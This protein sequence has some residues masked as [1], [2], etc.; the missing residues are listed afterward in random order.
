MNLDRLAADLASAEATPNYV[1]IAPNVCDDGH[2]RTCLDGT[3]G[4]LAA[5]DRFLRRLVPMIT[6][7]PAFATDGLLIV[8]F[9]EADGSLAEDSTAVARNGRCPVSHNKR[10]AWGLVVDGLGL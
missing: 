3:P 10:A 7:S 5:V 2:D 1:F 9:N 6:S 4:G 8:T